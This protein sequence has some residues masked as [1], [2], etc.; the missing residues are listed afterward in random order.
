MLTTL[1]AWRL[2]LQI[3]QRKTKS[4][5]REEM[6]LDI[7][8]FPKVEVGGLRKDLPADLAERVKDKD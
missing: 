8:K 4:H 3:S 5:P 6:A 7:F 1:Y 2:E